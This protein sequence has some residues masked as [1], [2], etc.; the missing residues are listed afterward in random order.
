[1]GRDPGGP[2]GDG[3]PDVVVEV[4]T[5]PFA[6]P[7]AQALVEQVQAEYV[8]R[9]G[10]PDQTPL[11][12]GTFDPPAGRF[13]VAFAGGVPAAMGGWRWRPDVQALDG[14]RV[15]E[16]K[17]MYVAPG[18]RRLGLG[19]RVLAVLES[20]AQAAGADVMVL[21]TGLRQP[22]ALALY[23]SAGYTD[24]VRFG[25]YADSDLAVFLGKPLT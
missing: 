14:R 23:R 6:H 4:Q 15:A 19:R 2:R 11:G 5:V 17:R 10:G 3:F 20:S 8:V 9:Y 24:T 21:E 13:L 22:E 18:H 16:V 7:A 12:P 25:H 1:M